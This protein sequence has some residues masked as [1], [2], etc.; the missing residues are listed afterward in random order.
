VICPGSNKGYIDIT[1]V[2]ANKPYTYTWSD[3][4]SGEDIS[5]LSPGYYQLTVTDD[6]GCELH[7]TFRIDYARPYA[8][9]LI[10][11]V[12]V[13][14]DLEKN[15]IVWE[16]TYGKGIVQYNIYRKDDPDGEYKYVGSGSAEKESVFIDTSSD[17]RQQSYR[18]K[19]A[20]VDTCGS[21]SVLSPYHRTMF[22]STSS[23][24]ETILL[25][26]QSYELEHGEMNFI[27]YIIYR[28]NSPTE[29]SP[30][31]TIAGGQT[32]YTDTDP[33]ALENIMYYRIGGI[34][35]GPCQPGKNGTLAENN[36]LSLSN[37][38]DNKNQITFTR[39][40]AVESD[41]VKVY[42]NPFEQELNIEYQLHS[43]K[44]VNVEIYNVLGHKLNT[45]VHD[46]QRPGNYR[47]TVNPALE[48]AGHAIYYLKITKGDKVIVRKIIH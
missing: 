41:G 46:I 18:Y 6:M 44:T 8:N 19:I 45:I 39:D 31:D 33:V 35:A 38:A 25:K 26:W 40:A 47:Y 13:D 15:R 36:G 30:L 48:V 16:K 2:G 23:D 43:G 4:T 24:N 37:L 34:M 29:L 42:P 32:E 17:P 22:L 10:C 5:G 27:S 9:N 3:S 20:G 12:T 7:E 11:M 21:E 1:P 28:G 14:G